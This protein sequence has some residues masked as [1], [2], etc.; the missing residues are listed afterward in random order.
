L[1]F[2]FCFYYT[3][4]FPVN[5][6]CDTIFRSRIP[7][8]MFKQKVI[9]FIFLLISFVALIPNSAK[10]QGTYNCAWE[11]SCFLDIAASN[12]QTGFTY[13]TCNGATQSACAGNFTCVPAGGPAPQPANC[14]SLN[15]DCRPA[16]ECGGVTRTDTNCTG[17]NIVCCIGSATTTGHKCVAVTGGE[18]T[19]FVCQP[20]TGASCTGQSFTGPNSFASCEAACGLPVPPVPP[21]GSPSTPSAPAS[22]ASCDNNLGIQTA[23]G[24][25]PLFPSTANA[26]MTPFVGFLLSWGA[27]IGGGIGMLLAVYAGFQIMTSAGNTQQLQAGKELLGAALSGLVLLIFAALVLRIIGA[28]IL[29]VFN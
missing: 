18:V 14:T 24:C 8:I 13:G 12:C 16:N 28:D 17:A 20:C 25:I 2:E 27:G 3:S 19:N 7:T 10:A 15:G 1:T 5:V 22:N 4:Q 6:Y 11:G 9:F 29:Q 21:G 23:I 26:G